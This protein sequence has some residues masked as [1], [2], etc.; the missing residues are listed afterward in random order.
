MALSDVSDAWGSGVRR[1][2]ARGL[3]AK[4]QGSSQA[5]WGQFS[6]MYSCFRLNRVE[7]IVPERAKGVRRSRWGLEANAKNR[8]PL[9]RVAGLWQGGRAHTGGPALGVF[10]VV[11]EVGEA[12]TVVRLARFCLA[13]PFRA[14]SLHGC[15]V[16]ALNSGPLVNPI[17]YSGLGL[18]VPGLGFRV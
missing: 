10:K 11:G 16:W 7:G 15:L 14:G 2:L 17:I 1:A 3:Q 6:E 5:N 8:D 18:R 13:V 4:S 12:E 9:W